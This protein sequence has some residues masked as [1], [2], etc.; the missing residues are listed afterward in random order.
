MKNGSFAS[1]KAPLLAALALAVA[2]SASA[3]QT[4]APSPSP[5]P[6]PAPAPP[7][8][9]APASPPDASSPAA[10]VPEWEKL[11]PSEVAARPALMLH[12]AANWEYG[13]IR[14]GLEKLRAAAQ[15]AGLKPAGLGMAAFTETE[16]SG[17]A[18]LPLEAAPG[19][20]PSLPDGVTL[21]ETPA[22][23]AIKFTH[24][25]SYDDIDATYDAI[26]AYLDEKGL[27]ATNVYLEEYLVDGK[28]AGDQA[29]K[30]EI[31]VF[32]K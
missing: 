21:G 15:K 26:T 29:L 10:T 9:S 22:G 20:K 3:A 28:D 13:K 30:V 25:G 19:A 17:F 32:L 12:S 7:A 27:D 14:E 11:K 8:A 23:K 6:T 2:M 4:P 16:D 24:T 1:C 18:V 31:Y 5:A